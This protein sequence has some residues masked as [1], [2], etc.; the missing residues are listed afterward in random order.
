MFE[1]GGKPKKNPAA[2]DPPWGGPRAAGFFSLGADHP[3]RGVLLVRRVLAAR[4]LRRDADPNPFDRLD[5][6][7]AVAALRRARHETTSIVRAIS[8]GAPFGN[9][10]LLM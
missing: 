5:R 8:V 2:A 4:L 3:M 9:A 1:G 7:A 6:F 10:A